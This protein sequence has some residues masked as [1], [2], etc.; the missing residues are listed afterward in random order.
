MPTTRLPSRQSAS[1]HGLGGGADD[2]ARLLHLEPVIAELKSLNASGEDSERKREVQITLLETLVSGGLDLAVAG[3][4]CQ[5][6]LN[7]QYDVVLA[8][9]TE[10]Q[11]N[12]I[13]KIFEANFIQGGTFASIAGGLFLTKHPTE[14]GELFLVSSGISLGLTASRFGHC[15]GAGAR[16]RPD[17]IRWQI[18]SI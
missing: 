14:A 1:R 11:S 13:Q 15:S 16:I 3:D 8:Q 12:F 6:E 4:R 10:R 5:K 2:A 17:Q 9:L 7:Y 18:F